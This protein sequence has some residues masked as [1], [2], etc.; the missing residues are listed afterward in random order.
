MRRRKPP[1]PDPPPLGAIVVDGANVI[2]TD[3]KGAISR[4]D[5]VVAWAAVF[6]PDLPVVVF[7][8]ASTARRLR[9]EQQDVLRARCAD[10]TPGR[11]RYAVTPRDE[12]ADPHLLRHAQLHQGLVVSNDRFFDEEEL[13]LGVLTLQFHIR[14]G[15][16][17][18]S[19]EAT[20]F[21]PSGGAQRVSVCDLAARPP[22]PEGG[23]R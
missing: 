12:P 2:E 23:D 9:P 13:R 22:E 7:V 14:G 1:L 19:D 20:W 21:R 16:F 17:V 6:R 15:A 11:A 3:G 5:L 8:D 18:P 10:V 4:L